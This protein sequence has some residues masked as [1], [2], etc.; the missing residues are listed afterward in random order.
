L[1][2][3]ITVRIEIWSSIL[4]LLSTGQ[5]RPTKAQHHGAIAWP[6]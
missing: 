3:F 5:T 6:D 1:G 4:R 2:G